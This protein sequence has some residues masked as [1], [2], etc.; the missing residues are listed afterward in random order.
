M[1]LLS[2]AEPGMGGCPRAVPGL[3]QPGAAGSSCVGSPAHQGQWQWHV[4]SF[5]HHLLPA[6]RENGGT[7]RSRCW[8][9]EPVH[10]QCCLQPGL[11]ACTATLYSPGVKCGRSSSGIP[12]ASRSAPDSVRGGLV[13]TLC[14]CFLLGSLV[15]PASP[16]TP[17]APHLPLPSGLRGCVLHPQF[18]NP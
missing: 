2:P 11:A 18:G 13:P 14:A 7:G 12:P 16:G 4:G 3:L 15:S 8:K 9:K 17:A 1:M 6:S 5:F 10:S